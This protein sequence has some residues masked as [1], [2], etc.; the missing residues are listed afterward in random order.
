[1]AGQPGGG[2]LVDRD[3]GIGAEVRHVALPLRADG[4]VDGP[5]LIG[6]ALSVAPAVTE[7]G[8]DDGNGWIEASWTPAAGA[9]RSEVTLTRPGDAR[10][11]SR[12]CGP[13]CGRPC[14]PRGWSPGVRTGRTG[15]VRAGPPR[16][17]A[18]GAVR[19]R[20]GPGHRAPLAGAR[21]HPD[22]CGPGVGRGG[23][24]PDRR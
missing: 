3:A 17:R 23:V 14:A 8:V 16:R 21:A 9:A 20:D 18:R 22:G 11:S 6:P 19:G 7:L 24:P 15:P 10:R 2:V 4:R 13:V 12:R 1:M 5:P